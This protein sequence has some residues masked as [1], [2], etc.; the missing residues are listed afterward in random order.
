MVS[1]LEISK[2]TPFR[3]LLLR[4][5]VTYNTALQDPGL[6]ATIKQECRGLDFEKRFEEVVGTPLMGWLSLLFGVH[7]MLTGHSQDDF[8]E[9]P[10]T[11]ILNRKTLL[12]KPTLSQAQVNDFFDAISSDFGALKLEMSQV[13]PVDERLDIVP[14]K[15]KPLLQTVPDNYACIDVSLVTEKLHN[16]PYFLLGNRLVGKERE[17]VF[18]AWGFLFEAYVNWLL[19]SIDGR[20]CASLYTDTHW[21]VNDKSFDAVIVKARMLVVMEFKSGFLAQS[22]RYSNDVTSFITDLDTKYGVGCK[23]LA[24]DI[25]FLFSA[26]KPKGTLKG[27]PISSHTEWVMPV[28]IVQDPMLNTPFVNYFLNQRFQSELGNPVING[29]IHVLPLNVIQITNLESL[30]EMADCSNLDVIAALHRRCRQHPLMDVEL[31]D[32]LSDLPEVRSNRCSPKFQAV[33]E[34]CTEEMC[35]FL[36]KDYSGAPT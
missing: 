36:F 20:H 14:F 2:P 29:R 19:K 25:G 28:M 4:S 27:I 30:V 13:R 33:F 35:A 21:Q 22:A 11:L 32:F 17:D 1:A 26:T 7:A 23:Q 10:E 31:E 6:L 24:R 9:K 15:I 8:K 3:N 5:Y 16:G 34:K 18:K 12:Q